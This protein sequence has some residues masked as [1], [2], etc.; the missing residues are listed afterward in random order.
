MGMKS[1]VKAIRMSA[2][3]WSHSHELCADILSSWFLV[4]TELATY[5]ADQFCSAAFIDP[6]GSSDQRLFFEPFNDLK[7]SGTLL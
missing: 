6:L 3:L 1:R 2:I 4:T 5:L 7:F